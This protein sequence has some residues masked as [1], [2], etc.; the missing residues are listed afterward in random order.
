MR[1]RLWKGENF[2]AENQCLFLCKAVDRSSCGL[3][4]C[5]RPSAAALHRPGA[6]PP[7]T[8]HNA[9]APAFS[10]LSLPLL[11][12]PLQP[13]LVIPARTHSPSVPA[14]G[15]P[16]DG[17]GPAAP[18]GRCPPGPPDAGVGAVGGLVE[19]GYCG[20]GSRWDCGECG[21]FWGMGHRGWGVL[22]VPNA[23]LYGGIGGL[24]VFGTWAPPHCCGS[25]LRPK[26]LPPIGSSL[27]RMRV[28]LLLLC[29]FAFWSLWAGNQV[30]GATEDRGCRGCGDAVGRKSSV[31]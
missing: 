20:V 7:G 14:A 10:S 21:A 3:V 30:T 9:H 1:G 25:W 16:P 26:L 27:G 23:A 28:W 13:S 24:S 15:P 12:G 8:P 6:K 29:P 31:G 5:R 2:S 18:G 17:D 11:R 4:K 22:A 19:R